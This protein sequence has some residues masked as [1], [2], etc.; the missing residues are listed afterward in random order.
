MT[1]AKVNAADL[2]VGAT[3]IAASPISDDDSEK[4]LIESA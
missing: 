2:L 4:G 1:W 3:L